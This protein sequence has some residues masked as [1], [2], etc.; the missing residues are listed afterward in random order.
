MTIEGQYNIVGA[1]PGDEGYSDLW[2]V[3]FAIV[4]EAYQANDWRS[5][6]TVTSSSSNLTAAEILV[7]CPVVP[8]GSTLQQR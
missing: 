3:H 8:A 4:P 7:N 1:V 6:D 2:Q 5:V